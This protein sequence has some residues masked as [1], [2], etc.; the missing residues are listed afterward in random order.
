M[1]GRDRD[2]KPID[3]QDAHYRP[4]VEAQREARRQGVGTLDAAALWWQCASHQNSLFQGQRGNSAVDIGTYTDH[5][6]NLGPEGLGWQRPADEAALTTAQLVA[7]RA[8]ARDAETHDLEEV[9][10]ACSLS[11]RR[12][13]FC[14]VDHVIPGKDVEQVKREL[15]DGLQ[16][17]LATLGTQRPR[18]EIVLQPTFARYLCHP[19][20]VGIAQTMLDAHVRIANVGHRNLLSDD[21]ASHGFGGFEVGPKENR[22]PHGREW[23]TDWCRSRIALSAS[24]PFR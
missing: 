1:A 6:G 18:S 10:A 8:Y 13:G 4:Y 12:Y 20:I 23:H 21:Q 24:S 7:T 3:S 14:C 15:S 17:H 19:A 22:G 2:L 16:Q 5:R 11:L 9:I